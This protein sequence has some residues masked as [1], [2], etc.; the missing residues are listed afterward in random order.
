MSSS[1]KHRS[2]AFMII[3]RAAAQYRTC[4]V[5][6]GGGCGSRLIRHGADP[7]VVDATGV[8]LS[9]FTINLV[10]Q[11]IWDSVDEYNASYTEFSDHE[12]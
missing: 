7:S 5:R 8:Q 10:F 12:D 9:F 6:S 1:G 3:S 2:S 11:S 4:A